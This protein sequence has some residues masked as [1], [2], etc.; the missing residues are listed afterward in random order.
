MHLV[1]LIVEDCSPLD[2]SSNCSAFDLKPHGEFVDR[3]CEGGSCCLLFARKY[4]KGII[5]GCLRPT[6]RVLDGFGFFS[7]AMAV[8]LRN[9]NGC[10]KNCSSRLLMSTLR[11]VMGAAAVQKCRSTSSVLSDLLDNVLE[12]SFNTSK[13]LQCFFGLR[14]C[15]LHDPWS[16]WVT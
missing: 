11:L 6:G 12:M 13:S 14:L 15:A 10:G 1:H 8:A 4:G 16:S 2:V 5:F 3:L 9:Q 7:S